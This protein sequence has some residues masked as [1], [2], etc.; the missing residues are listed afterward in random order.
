MV[1]V[2]KEPERASHQVN[3]VTRKDRK[4]SHVP[5]GPMTSKRAVAEIGIIR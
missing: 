2:A 3:Y 5:D 1:P 4:C